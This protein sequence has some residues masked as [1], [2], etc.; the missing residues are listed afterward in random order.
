MSARL[1]N[2]LIALAESWAGCLP[3]LCR[4]DHITAAITFIHSLITKTMQQVNHTT[5]IH[6]TV[7]G[8]VTDPDS[9]RALSN[10]SALEMRQISTALQSRLLQAR[11]FPG[12]P[13]VQ[14]EAIAAASA[15]AL[16]S[17][18]ASPDELREWFSC[19]LAPL[20]SLNARFEGAADCVSGIP[21]PEFGL[22]VEAIQEAVQEAALLESME[23]EVLQGIHAA[24]KAF[25]KGAGAFLNEIE[26]SLQA[27]W[28]EREEVLWRVLEVVNAP[29]AGV[30][31]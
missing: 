18:A 25:Y 5:S 12:L 21:G 31:Y 24:A 9:T 28:Q 7:T 6:R 2:A 27:F 17:G 14:L 26:G 4:G 22:L 11:L 23:E 13:D 8:E 20:E 19:R 29:Y 15:V 30:E 16:D 1:N 10:I 3:A